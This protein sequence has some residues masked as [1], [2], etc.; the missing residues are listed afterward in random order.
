MCLSEMS[1][2]MCLTTSQ[3]NEWCSD[4]KPWLTVIS[5][6]SHTVA[7]VIEQSNAQVLK[8]AATITISW[9]KPLLACIFQFSVPKPHLSFSSN[10]QKINTHK[11]KMPQISKPR[12]NPHSQK[13]PQNQESPSPF[14]IISNPVHSTKQK[15][16]NKTKHR[17]QTPIMPILSDI[18]NNI[19][20]LSTAHSTAISIQKIAYLKLHT[21]QSWRKHDTTLVRRRTPEVKIP[22]YC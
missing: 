12:L 2:L 19:S 3:A 15:T 10:P 21:D 14:S 6:F 11:K 13:N 7:L 8:T 16:Q 17:S 18:T 22:G 5:K 9:S 1:R 20:E 4:F